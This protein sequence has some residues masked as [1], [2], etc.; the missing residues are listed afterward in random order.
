[1]ALTALLAAPVLLVAR[2]VLGAPSQ[3]GRAGA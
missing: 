1:M 2:R 3:I